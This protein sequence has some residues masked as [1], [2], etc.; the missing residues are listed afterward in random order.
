MARH[1]LRNIILDLFFGGSETTSNTLRWL[2]LFM[3]LNPDKQVRVQVFEKWTFDKF[4]GKNY[5]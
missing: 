5:S 4:L 2:I 3:V 1:N